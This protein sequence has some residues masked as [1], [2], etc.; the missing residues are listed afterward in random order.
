MD[1]KRFDGVRYVVGVVAEGGGVS[2]GRL[3]S[4]IRRRGHGCGLFVAGK[5]FCRRE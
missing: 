2:G 5:I 1:N 3:L 4:V